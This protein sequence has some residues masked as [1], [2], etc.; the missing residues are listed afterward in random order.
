MTLRSPKLKPQHAPKAPHEDLE[1]LQSTPARP[2]RIL[3]E[4]LQPMM[5]LKKEN[6]GDTIVIFGSARIESRETA[7]A[8][9]QWSR[10]ENRDPIKTYNKTAIAAAAL[11]LLGRG[12]LGRATPL[13]PERAVNS[14]KGDLKWVATQLKSAER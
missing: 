2:V 5:Q 4:Y 3:A 13:I 12:A 10:V 14:L 11:A 6:I 9:L 1:F 7:L 8:R